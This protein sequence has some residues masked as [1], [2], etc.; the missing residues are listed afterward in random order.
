MQR[1]VAAELHVSWA[2]T[3]TLCINKISV[4]SNSL[5]SRSHHTLTFIDIS[6]RTSPNESS[7]AFLCKIQISNQSHAVY[8]ARPKTIMTF[9]VVFSSISKMFIS[10]CNLFLRFHLLYCSAHWSR[11]PSSKKENLTFGSAHFELTQLIWAQTA[12]HSAPTTHTGDWKSS[13]LNVCPGLLPITPFY[14]LLRNACNSGNSGTVS[15]PQLLAQLYYHS[16][17]LWPLPCADSYAC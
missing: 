11:C 14:R 5:T 2:K 3:W 17:R 8:S 13:V 10:W 16:L 15:C 4:S 6:Q 12:Q 7:A 9:G 1:L